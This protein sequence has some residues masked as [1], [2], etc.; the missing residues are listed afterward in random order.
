MSAFGGGEVR[1]DDVADRPRFLLTVEAQPGPVP[2]PI[3]VRWWLKYG[4]R[5][6]GLRCRAVAELPPDRTETPKPAANCSRIE[7]DGT[8]PKVTHGTTEATKA[9]QT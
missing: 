3:R 7:S 8:N 1:A 5:V 4:L 9:R 2:V 6:C